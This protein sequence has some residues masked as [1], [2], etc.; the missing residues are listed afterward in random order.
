[1]TATRGPKAI[2]QRSLDEIVQVL[3][4]ANI[5]VYEFDGRI[6]R[7]SGGCEDLY[8]WTARE[9]L[10]RNPIEDRPS[11]RF[12]APIL[13][14]LCRLRHPPHLRPPTPSFRSARPR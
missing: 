4:D 9:A 6:V 8:G 3:D 14:G 2:S 5:L 7:W 13:D 12:T 11:M 10:G 1:M